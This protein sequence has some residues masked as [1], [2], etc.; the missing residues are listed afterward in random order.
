MKKKIAWIIDSTGLMS[1][2]LR[3]HPDVFCVPL[4]IQFEGKQYQDNVDLTTDELYAR[5]RNEK[6]VPKTSQPSPG[7]FSILYEALK[8]NY[9]EAIAVHA[10][11]KLSGTIG[12][13]ETGA[14]L[15]DFKVTTIDS[16]SLSGGLTGLVEH[17]IDLHEQGYSVEEI[18][19][20]LKEK[21]QS[22]IAYAL[23]G[24]LEQLKKSG[25]VTG[26]QFFIGSLLNIK[27]IVRIENGELIPDKKIR[28]EKRAVRYLRDLVLEQKD[29]I[30]GTLFIAHGNVLNKA[31]ALKEEILFDAPHLSIEIGNLNSSLATHAGEGSLAVLWF[32][33]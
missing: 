7:T 4:S 28:S 17:G 30:K 29:K 14:H 5:I 23:V 8:E 18:V 32:T 31:K 15:A 2:K 1:D 19:N 21:Q 33:R 24:Q 20:D 6:E 11:S 9:D 16:G 3:H 10:S 27:P 25:R 13:S 26:I 12:S 22:H